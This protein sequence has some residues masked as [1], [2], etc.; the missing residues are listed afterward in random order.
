MPTPGRL[1]PA[2]VVAR[3]LFFLTAIGVFFQV[4]PSL[5]L[6]ADGTTV[7][8]PPSSEELNR[9]VQHHFATQAGFQEGDLIT[10]EATQALLVKLQEKGWQVKDEDELLERLLPEGDFLVKQL[11]DT[12]GREFLRK[13][14]KYPGGVDRLDRLARMPQGKNNVNDLIRKVP[15]GA[16][17][18]QAMTTTKEGKRLGK[19]LSNTRSGKNFNQTTGKIYFVPQL[20]QEL[21]GRLAPVQ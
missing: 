3:L 8:R 2:L 13:I 16:D 1:R 7:V 20:A 9:F 10:R 19:S 15:N 11:Q 6:A 17:W 4:V 12:K 5:A 21:D 18:I 14:Q